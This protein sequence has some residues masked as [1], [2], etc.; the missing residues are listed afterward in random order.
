MLLQNDYDYIHFFL[1]LPHIFCRVTQSLC[2]NAGSIH[3]LEML[4]LF[5]PLFCCFLG[6]MGRFPGLSLYLHFLFYPVYC[7]T[8]QEPGAPYV[9]KISV[10]YS[11]NPA[12]SVFIFFIYTF[13]TPNFPYFLSHST[14]PTSS[15]FL[16]SPT[17]YRTICGCQRLTLPPTN[18]THK[19]SIVKR[20]HCI[21]HNTPHN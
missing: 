21:T 1:V 20:L 17:C 18:N 6:L 19:L 4:V 13:H 3:S 11:E 15:P 8:S 10:T 7:Y 2:R 5:L 16:F 12:R 14:S 9:N